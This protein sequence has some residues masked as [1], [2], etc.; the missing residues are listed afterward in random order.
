MRHHG[1]GGNDKTK[2][3][4]VVVHIKVL[5]GVGR[6]Q[7]SLIHEM[8]KDPFENEKIVATMHFCERCNDG[9]NHP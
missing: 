6:K 4:T 7:R 8:V 2:E 9:Q 3:R 5:V 1:K